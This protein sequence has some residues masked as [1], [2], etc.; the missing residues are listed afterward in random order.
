MTSKFVL[1]SSSPR[2]EKLFRKLGLDFRIISPNVVE[3]H[4]NGESPVEYVRRISLEKALAVAATLKHKHIVI[5]A[6]TIVVCDGDILGKPEDE[7]EAKSMLMRLSG[8]YHHV[9]TGL[10]I[11]KSTSE[12]MH[13]ENVKSTVKFKSLNPHEIEEYVNT[14]EPSDKAGGYAAQGI[15]AFMIEEIH[16]SF[17]NIVGLPLSSLSNALKNLGII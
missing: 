11:V 13:V 14:K 1:A 4:I 15:G 7:E 2:R 5:G 3:K 12:I 6:D 9:I 10:S 8:R 16:G 17:T